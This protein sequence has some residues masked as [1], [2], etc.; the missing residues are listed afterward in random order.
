AVPAITAHHVVDEPA[1]EGD[2]TSCADRD[3]QVRNGT[4]TRETRVDVDDLR[5]VDLRLH[6]P[7]Q[8][9]RMALRHVGAHDDQTV[10][11]LQVAPVRGRRASTKPCPQT[12][13]AGAVS[14]PG[15]V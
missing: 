11:V 12:G 3:V 15:L 14:Y 1:E 7:A 5:A 10:R 13:D 8:C 6:R 9:H 2:V 4:R